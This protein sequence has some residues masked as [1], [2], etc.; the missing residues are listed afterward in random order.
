[1][2]CVTLITDCLLAWL[3]G[4]LRLWTTRQVANKCDLDTRDVTTQ[5]GQALANELGC[6]Y[7]ESSAKIH[8]N[9]EEAFQELVRLVRR[10]RVLENPASAPEVD[11]NG[12][13]KKKKGCVLL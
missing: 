11:A 9:V 2:H 4:W 10:A 13:P 5:E 6:P 1:M 3:I 7:F 12:V 8:V